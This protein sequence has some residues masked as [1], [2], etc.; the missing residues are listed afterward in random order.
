MRWFGESWGAPACTPEEHV[1]TPIGYWCRQCEK[2]IVVGD[3]GFLLP[4]CDGETV[5]QVAWHLDC[6]GAEP[7]PKSP[8][9]R[10]RELL[11]AFDE[12]A[13]FYLTRTDKS[14]R[15]TTLLELVQWAGEQ[16]DKLEDAPSGEAA[17]I[18]ARTRRRE[19]PTSVIHVLSQGFAL[20]GFSRRVPAHWP[21][22]HKWVALSEW[23]QVTCPECRKLCEDPGELSRPCTGGPEA[24]AWCGARASFVCTAADGM[25]W[26]AC[27]RGDHQ[28]GST[29]MESLKA[30]FARHGLVPS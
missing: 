14:L 20:C 30:W 6:L 10:L 4:H 11:A 1:P 28:R 8:R 24:R 21:P 3:R 7:K 9:A 5:Q 17:E 16:V 15:N 23:R 12:L 13:A 26:F 29:Q 22:G 27:E 2:P 19:P 25:Q 18:A